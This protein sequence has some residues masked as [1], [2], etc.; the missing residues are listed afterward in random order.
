[1]ITRRHIA[2][3]YALCLGLW[4][5]LSGK[6]DPLLLG[7]GAASAALAVFVAVRMEII[8][9]E[10]HPVALSG[11][12]AWYWLWLAGQT[13]KAN[14]QMARLILSPTLAID[15]VV[16]D[17]HT[18]KRSDIGRAIFANSITL[19]PGTVSLN[20]HQEHIEVYAITPQNLRT[21]QA[22]EMLRR[23]PDPADSQ[24]EGQQ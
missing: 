23:I 21:L 17:V 15:P 24:E 16:G 9:H 14:T 1:M 12:L 20:V 10:S 4:F 2:S 3:L 11:R 6:T 22:G 7:L 5:L 8:D 19:T 13:I 18:G